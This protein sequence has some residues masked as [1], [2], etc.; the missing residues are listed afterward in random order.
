MYGTYVHDIIHGRLYDYVLKLSKDCTPSTFVHL[1]VCPGGRS[2]EI[3]D[4]KLSFA[5]CLATKCDKLQSQTLCGGHLP[6]HGHRQEHQP[7][8]RTL[9]VEDV[10][11]MLS[12]T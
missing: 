11:P 1:C 8:E 6:W 2:L 3:I 12:V 10:T 9:N 7:T 4:F 5:V